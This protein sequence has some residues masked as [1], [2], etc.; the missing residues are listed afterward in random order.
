MKKRFIVTGSLVLF[1]IGLG[2]N[3]LARAQD[4]NLNGQTEAANVAIQWNQAALQGV[5]DPKLG[6]PMVSRVLANRPHF[7]VRRVGGL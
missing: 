7:H 2:I 1:G 3:I 4:Q 5:R 6:P